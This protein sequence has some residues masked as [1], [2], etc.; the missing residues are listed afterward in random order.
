M[1]TLTTD[2]MASELLEDALLTLD[3]ITTGVTVMAIN[4]TRNPVHSPRVRRLLGVLMALLQ[5][6]EYDLGNYPP[7]D[8]CG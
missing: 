1:S 5:D 8:P 3:Q 4:A 7:H 2:H 6:A